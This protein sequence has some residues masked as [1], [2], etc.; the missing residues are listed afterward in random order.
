M[1]VVH[2]D[3]ERPVRASASN[4]LRTAQK[5]SSLVPPA[6]QR[7]RALGHPL[8][9]QLGLILA[10]QRGFCEAVAIIAADRSPDPTDGARDVPDDPGQ[11]PVRNALPVGQ[12]VPANHVARPAISGRE[13]PQSRDLP[14]RRR[15][16][17]SAGGRPELRTVSSNTAVSSGPRVVAADEGRVEVRARPGAC[18]DLQ[19]GEGVDRLAVLQRSRTARPDLTPRRGRAGT[20][21]PRSGSRPASCL[22]EALGHGHHF[23]GDELVPLSV[24]AR[25]HLARVD[26]GPVRQPD[27]PGRLEDRWFSAA[28]VSR[29]STAVRSARSASSSCR[30]AP[31]IPP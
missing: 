8:G 6:C 21:R 18:E 24:V 30:P 3:D 23:A 27:V 4:S 19:H 29:I 25:D 28:S 10:R 16:A 14:I 11:R 2:H 15:R 22:F 17:R 13:L 5:V 26:S 9:D 7:G 31:R 20:S 12:A 1:Q